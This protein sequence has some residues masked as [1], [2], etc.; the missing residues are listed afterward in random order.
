M[1]VPY[2]TKFETDA[3]VESQITDSTIIGG[4]TTTSTIPSTGNIH[5]IGVGAGTYTNWG[6]MVV[7]TNNIGT[8]QRI[9]GVY[10]VSLAPISGVV[11]LSS[12][13]NSTSTTVGLNLAGAKVL[14]DKIVSLESDLYQEE[15]TNTSFGRD[16]TTGQIVTDSPWVELI[17]ATVNGILTNFKLPSFTGVSVPGNI[18]VISSNKVIKSKTAVTV[19]GVTTD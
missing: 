2:Y 6:G 18:F 15:I 14:N 17:P 8:L 13:L 5:A 19:T 10:S 1:A 7:P 4:V 9:N 3:K 11:T 16:V 12:D